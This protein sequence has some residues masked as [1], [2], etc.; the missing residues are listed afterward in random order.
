MRLSVRH[1][2]T[3]RFSAPQARV[4]QLARLTPANCSGQA[5]LSWD[6]SASADVRLRPGRDGYGNA[7]TMLYVDGPLD[8]LVIEAAGE[9]LTQDQAGVVLNAPEP[10]PPTVFLRGSDLTQPDDAI[11]AL[12]DAAGQAGA[13]PLTRMHGLMRLIGARMRYDTAATDVARSGADALRLGHGVCQDLTHIFCA[14]ARLL[15]IPARY[16]SGHL[17]QRDAPAEQGAAHAWA[18]AW[19]EGLGW[20]GF[21]AVNGISPDDAYVRVAVGLD[22]REAAP[23]AGARVGGGEERLEVSIRVDQAGRR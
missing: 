18:E 10:L 2:T 23:L 14:A 1:R 21:D 11:R 20:V 9:V 6:L 22:Y 8:E 13:D 12:A 19:I 15:D 17:F 4:I 16:V 3:Y 7:I 5:I